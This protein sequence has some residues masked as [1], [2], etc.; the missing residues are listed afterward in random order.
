MCR[1]GGRTTTIVRR[2]CCVHRDEIFV[3]VD[4]RIVLNREATDS[5][6]QCSKP[7]LA[8]ISRCSAALE[9]ILSQRHVLGRRQFLIKWKGFD[10][11]TWED[12]E[13]IQDPNLIADL[14]R[15]K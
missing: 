10:K 9:K 12:E 11:P 5:E 6:V 3:A 14:E 15:R 1:S 2:R 7:A 4:V 13:C 8:S